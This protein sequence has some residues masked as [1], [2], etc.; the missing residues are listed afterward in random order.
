LVAIANR[1]NQLGITRKKTPRSQE[2][3]E[4]KRQEYLDKLNKIEIDKIV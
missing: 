1:L 2:R 4:E 3:A